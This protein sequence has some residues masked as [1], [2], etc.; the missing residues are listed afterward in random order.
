MDPH[1]GYQQQHGWYHHQQQ[2]GGGDFRDG[3]RGGFRG[4]RGGYQG[5]Y[6]GGYSGRGKGYG[7]GTVIEGSS[8]RGSYMKAYDTSYGR[9]FKI[10]ANQDVLDNATLDE[11]KKACEKV[12][13]DRDPATLQANRTAEILKSAIQDAIGSSG[14]QPVPPQGAVAHGET[15]QGAAVADESSRRGISAESPS[16]KSWISNTPALSKGGVHALSLQICESFDIKELDSDKCG[17]T[18]HSLAKF[19]G[20]T[21][22]KSTFASRDDKAVAIQELSEAFLRSNKSIPSV[23]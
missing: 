7:K 3:F 1:G 18:F 10:T 4:G 17:E 8:V 21:L 11:L 23:D 19:V 12:L 20:I 15:A 16:N 22:S 6:Q 2:Q 14:L 5:G 9:E 13:Q